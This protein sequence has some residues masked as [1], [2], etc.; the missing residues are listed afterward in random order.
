M[1]RH[2]AAAPPTP[3]AHRRLSAAPL[4]VGDRRLPRD[5][6]PRV[7]RPSRRR[8]RG[9]RRP[10]R[11][12]PTHAMCSP[13][14]GRGATGRRL[15]P[16]PAC[17]VAVGPVPPLAPRAW[18]WS[19]SAA[20]SHRRQV[21]PAG[22]LWR[23]ESSVAAV[24]RVARR[25]GFLTPP[26]AESPAVVGRGGAARPMPSAFRRLV[27]APLIVGGCRRPRAPSP[28]TRPPPGRQQRV[29]GRPRRCRPTHAKC[30]PPAGR[31]AAGRRRSPT[32]ECR[33]AV[34]PAR[35]RASRARRES[36]SGAPSHRLQVLPAGFPWRRES[37]VAATARVARRHGF[38]A[39]VRRQ[40]RG[41]GRLRPRR[42]TRRAHR[43]MVAAPPVVGACCH[44]RP[45][46]VVPHA[47]RPRLCE[48]RMMW[49]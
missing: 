25:R 28:R 8:E 33:L 6:S 15:S 45:P 2:G 31:G 46:R 16:T 1:A 19:A 40:E 14:A 38:R 29:R 24:A 9:G 26:G 17:R 18:R 23:R 32:P 5:P 43:Q 39:P 34:R 4:V 27:V 13:P 30:S 20:P 22:F 37:S 48:L 36:A 10:R 3:T 21:L 41:V 44:P 35:P 49:R 7:P 12:R 47:L 11:R 42:P